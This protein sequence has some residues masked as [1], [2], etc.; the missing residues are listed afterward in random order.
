MGTKYRSLADA[1]LDSIRRHQRQRARPGLVAVIARKI[2]RLQHI[3]LSTLT[4]SDV[5][6]RT[7][8]GDNLRLPHP[9]G[10]VIHGDVRIGDNCMVMQQVTIGQLASGGVP[11]LGS[12]VYIGAGAKVLGPVMIGDGAQVGANAVVLKD[13]PPGATAV[14]I[15]ARIIPARS[16]ESPF[17]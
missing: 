10:V 1:L 3:A 17:P 2:A 11:V 14:G 6:I 12:H 4:A 16:D 15:P 5:D 8:F 9:T 13:V 7:T